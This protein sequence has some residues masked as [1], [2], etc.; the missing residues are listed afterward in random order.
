MMNPFVWIISQILGIYS[1]IVIVWIILSWLI[2]FNVVNRH[3]R[4]VQT[5]E[6]ILSRLVEPVLRPIRR[7]VPPIG[8]ID[9]SPIIL[10]LVI[11][12]IQYALV[13]YF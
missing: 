1:F 8:G 2:G 6:H 4:F 12:F 9:I 7:F 11:S 13:Y 10:F 5:V 3:N